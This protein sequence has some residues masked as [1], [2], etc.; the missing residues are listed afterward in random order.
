MHSNFIDIKMDPQTAVVAQ[1]DYHETTGSFSTQKRD[2]S[3]VQPQR[4]RN[5]LVNI[6][7]K[8]VQLLPYD[9]HFEKKN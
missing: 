4:V 3:R 2:A 7:S 1:M 5:S 9:I 8:F 6:G